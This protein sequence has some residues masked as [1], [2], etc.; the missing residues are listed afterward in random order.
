MLQNKRY[1][2]IVPKNEITDIKQKNSA[3]KIPLVKRKLVF[4]EVR[5]SCILLNETIVSYKTHLFIIIYKLISRYSSYLMLICRKT[6]K[7]WGLI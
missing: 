2:K 4:V 1:C 7:V 3:L 6:R 5:N